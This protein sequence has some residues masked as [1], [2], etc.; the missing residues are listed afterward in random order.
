MRIEETRGKVRRQDR[1]QTEDM[2]QKEQKGTGWE[3]RKTRD[4]KD[5]EMQGEEIRKGEER[6]GEQRVHISSPWV[7]DPS[8]RPSGLVCICEHTH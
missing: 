8:W 1:K 7:I 4:K 2:K 6:R 5:K 3:K